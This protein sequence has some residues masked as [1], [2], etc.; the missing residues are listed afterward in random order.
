MK[1][2]EYMFV[3]LAVMGGLTTM[4]DTP[5]IVLP[6]VMFIGK[7]EAALLLAEARQRVRFA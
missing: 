7:K 5:V 3:I 6:M 1:Y 2:Y 4:S